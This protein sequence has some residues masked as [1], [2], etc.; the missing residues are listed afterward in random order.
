MTIEI[1]SPYELRYVYGFDNEESDRV[2]AE[3]RAALG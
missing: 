2:I 1:I 3:K